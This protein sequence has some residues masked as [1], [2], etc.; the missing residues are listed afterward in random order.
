MLRASGSADATL[1]GTEV[2][3]TGPH[4]EILILYE[5]GEG[6]AVRA[7]SDDEIARSCPSALDVIAEI[8][9]WRR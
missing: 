2:H 9:S 1:K 7:A 5:S 8:R 6:Y 3:V 4:G